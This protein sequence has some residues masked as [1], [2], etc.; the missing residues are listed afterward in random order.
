M[1]P[2]NAC[3]D[4]FE[5][6]NKVMHIDDFRILNIGSIWIFVVAVFGWLHAYEPIE[7]LRQF[8]N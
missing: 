6:K 5:P 2:T 3:L 7:I 8:R 4:C 1:R